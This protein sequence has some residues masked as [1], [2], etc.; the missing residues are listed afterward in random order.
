MFAM[1]KMLPIIL[2]IAGAGYA[3]HTTVVSQKDAIIARL[4]SNAVTLKENA[5][6]LE[7]AFESEK[8]AR[9]RS[10]NNLQAQLQAVGELTEKNTAM[11]AEMDDYLSIFKRHNLTK[12]ARAKPG[13]IEPRINN[14]TQ[15]VFRAIEEA[16]KEVENAD[17]Q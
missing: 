7:T 17:S 14:G 11:Q 9:E 3:Y 15:E 10:E 6:R 12:L 16:S 13:L 2:L 5:M 4:E 1:L 8:A